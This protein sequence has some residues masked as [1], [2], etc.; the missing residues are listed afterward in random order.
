MDASAYG[1]HRLEKRHQLA[2]GQKLNY[3]PPAA[4]GSVSVEFRTVRPFGINGE[5]DIRLSFTAA[6]IDQFSRRSI[7]GAVYGMADKLS[8]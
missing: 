2:E 3:E 4:D 7:A 5:Y 1:A 8:S 6:E